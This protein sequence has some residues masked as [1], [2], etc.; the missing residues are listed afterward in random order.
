MVAFVSY[1]KE[2]PFKAFLID[3]VK[4]RLEKG[5]RWC[6]EWMKPLWETDTVYRETF[7]M[8]E[9]DG[10]VKAPFLFPPERILCVESYDG[11]TAYKRERDYKVE[12]GNLVLTKDSSI[13]HT[14]WG[15]FFYDTEEEARQALEKVI[16]D[17]ISD[18]LRLPMGNLLIWS[19]S[20]IRNL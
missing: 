3:K 7:A 17:W 10:M 9:E 8:I 14:G 1:K 4:E 18:R 15:T 12:D 11:E 20:A 2:T 6:E 16:L 13:P 19:Q 5:E